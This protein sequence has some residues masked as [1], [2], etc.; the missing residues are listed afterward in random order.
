MMLN[1]KGCHELVE[2]L[3]GNDIGSKSLVIS[4]FDDVES[5]TA[6]SRELVILLRASSAF[7]ESL[8]KPAP[9]H[10]PISYTS[11]NTLLEELEAVFVELDTDST[12]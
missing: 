6:T 1:K 4:Y 8:I 11:T 3:N 10:L 5:Y 9:F 12:G 7:L 2:S